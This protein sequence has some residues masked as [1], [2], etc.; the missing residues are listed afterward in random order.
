MISISL[1]NNKGGVGKTTLTCNIAA[2]FALELRKRVLLVDCDPQ[3]NTTQLVLDEE[4]TQKL[5]RQRD[6]RAKTGTILDVVRPLQVGDA[7][8]DTSITPLLASANRF[9]ADLLAGHPRLSIVEDILSQAWSEAAGGTIGGLRKSNWCAAL[10]SSLQDKYDIVFFDI[11]PSLGSLNRTVLLGTQYFL[12]PMGADLFSIFGVRNIAEW[13]TH[14]LRV[15]DK[16]F[17]LS[18]HESPGALAE[19]QIAKEPAIKQGFAGYTVQQYITK[20]KAGTRR[21]T[22]AYERLLKDIPSEVEKSLGSFSAA[23]RDPATMHLGDVPHMY[24]LVPLAQ[25]VNAPI[26]ELVAKDGL[27]GSQFKQRDKYVSDLAAIVQALARN[28]G[29]RA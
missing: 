19:F 2:Q 16:G 21:P 20:S 1:F 12:S 24:S 4:I 10:C 5:Y 23:G 15:Y 26:R 6:T 7:A 14:W 11:G 22:K 28:V 27:V 25:S 18:E 3:C 9:G 17:E 13:L 29:M 8:I